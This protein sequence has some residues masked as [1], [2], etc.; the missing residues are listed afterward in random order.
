MTV[1]YI[2]LGVVLFV[3]FVVAGLYNSLIAKRNMVENAF[4]TIDV[5][6]K[7]RF[8]LIPNI[9][10]SV[11]Q[12]MTHERETLTTIAEMRSKAMSGPTTTND[13]VAM[14]N[15]MTKLLGGI[16]VAVEA[17]PQLKADQ[18]FLQL[19]RTLNE[20]EEQLSASRRAYNAA[21]TD[22]N[23][24]IEVFPTNIIAA[25]LSFSRKQLFEAASAERAPVS[26]KNLFQ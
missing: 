2:T 20:V 8:D 6:L 26:V 18:S 15:Q 7:K 16:M 13:K 12:Y 3:G 4:A 22:F 23:I 11:K 21:A 9:V 25:Q 24:S 5:M 17:Y 19:Q 10:E 14:D 1:G